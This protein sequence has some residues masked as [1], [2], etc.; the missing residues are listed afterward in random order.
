MV[1]K[2]PPSPGAYIIAGCSLQTC[3]PFCHS[4]QT[5]FGLF[6]SQQ[7]ADAV[8]QEPQINHSGISLRLREINIGR[9]NHCRERM[10]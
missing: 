2:A 7:Q 5:S 6:F 9:D 10:S 4:Y 3:A 8:H 1:L